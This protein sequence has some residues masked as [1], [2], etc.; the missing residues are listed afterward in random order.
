MNA[1]ALGYAE[2]VRHFATDGLPAPSMRKGI[3][4]VVDIVHESR[5][6]SA[7]GD[8][9]SIDMQLLGTFRQPRERIGRVHSI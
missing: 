7:V 1:P 5:H 8:C 6:G 9:A 3:R 2:S 4:L